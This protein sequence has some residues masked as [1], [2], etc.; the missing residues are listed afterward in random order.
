[1]VDKRYNRVIPATY[2]TAPHQQQVDRAQAQI[3]D[4]LLAGR[5]SLFKP[6]PPG[7][8]RSDDVLDERIAE[9]LDFVIRQ[10]RE[11][12]DILSGYPALIS[13]HAPKL[14]QI[15]LIQQ[16]LGQLGQVVAS[17]D[18]SMAVDRITLT[19]LKARLKRKAV[20][21]IVA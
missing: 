3:R 7:P 11:I 9:E 14:Q 16:V 10:L 5:R 6:P 21:P 1:M 4:D 2:V 15:D 12:G 13:R 19:E 20:R 8:G 18:K 17:A